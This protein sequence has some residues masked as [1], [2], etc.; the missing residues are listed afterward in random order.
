MKVHVKPEVCVGHGMCPLACPEIF[1]LSD[2]DGHA[3]VRMEDVPPELEAA[4]DAAVRG[5]PE[6]AIETF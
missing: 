6:G 5:C 3:S 2:E 1:V 4:V